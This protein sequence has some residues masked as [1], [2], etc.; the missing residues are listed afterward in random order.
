MSELITRTVYGSFLQTNQLLGLPHK[1]LKNTTQNERF[2]IQSGVLPPDSRTPVL[3]LWGVGNGGHMMATG[4][5]GVQYPKGLQHKATDASA[6]SPMPLILREPT[7]D[8]TAAER[9]LFCG[10]REEQHQGRT[11]IAYYF[12]WLPKVG[13]EAVMEYHVVKDGEDVPSPFIPDTSNLNPVPE[14][15][16]SEGVN[17]ISGDYV[18][19]TARTP[20]TMSAWL[21][22]EFL[23]VSR[24][25]YDTDELAIISELVMCSSVPKV[26]PVSSG[27]VNFQFNEAVGIQCV[28]HFSCFFPMKYNNNG[29]E[30][31]LDIGA[32]EP[33]FAKQ[34]LGGTASSGLV[35]P[36]L[37]A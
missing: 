27:G 36:G 28:S 32:T 8:L 34:T 25:M 6:F 16:S 15:L 33:L 23:N 19:T 21:A 10:R 7:N 1:I 17:V 12:C 35:S 26:V 3:N 14:M 20:L 24:V 22:A 30:L 5:G 29:V 9:N 31:L 13:V 4:P 18:S 37:G 11:W 2:N